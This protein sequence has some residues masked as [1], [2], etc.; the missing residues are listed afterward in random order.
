MRTILIAAAAAMTIGIASAPAQAFTLPAGGGLSG[1]GDA[2][3]IIDDAQVFV[4]GGRPYCFY[5]DAW[6]GPGWYRCGYAW[7]QGIGFG[8]AYGWNRWYAPR[9]HSRYARGD[10]RH[11]RRDGRS[12]RRDFRQER[13]GNRQ[14]FRQERRGDR[15]QFRQERRQQMQGQ[16]GQ[17][18]GIG[19][20]GNRG[21]GMG[22]GG[23]GGM[24][25]GGGGMGGGGGGG[26]G[27]GGGGMGGR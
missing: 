3:T 20:G 25:G 22:G 14:E 6:N 17:Q 11:F 18:R 24:G 1:A 13:R 2:V 16:R 26:M 5:V 8:G 23:G 9:Y 10:F 12:N 19:G 4:F 27:G 15:Q 21:G 7:R